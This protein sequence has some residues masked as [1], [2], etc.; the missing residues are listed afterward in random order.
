MMW[1]IDVDVIQTNN[2][3]MY[4]RSRKCTFIILQGNLLIREF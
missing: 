4:S 1:L 2:Y 3:T